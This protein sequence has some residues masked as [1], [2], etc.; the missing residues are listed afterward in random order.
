MYTLFFLIFIF[1]LSIFPIFVSLSSSF[2]LFFS[3]YSLSLSLSQPLSVNPLPSHYLTEEGESMDNM[4][5]P[6][7]HHGIHC[8]WTPPANYASVLCRMTH[9]RIEIVARAKQRRLPLFAHSSTASRSIFFRFPRRPAQ[10]STNPPT[11]TTLESVHK[12]SEM[13]VP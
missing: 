7:P 6:V 4:I 11:L 5:E 8:R 13:N 3:T 9:P 1:S 2:L 10:T 12:W